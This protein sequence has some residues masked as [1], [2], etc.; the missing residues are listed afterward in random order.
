MDRNWTRRL[1][2]AARR[3]AVT[4]AN[5]NTLQAD[6]YR[7]LKNQFRVTGG[8][9]GDDKGDSQEQEGKGKDLWDNFKRHIGKYNEKRELILPSGGRQGCRLYQTPGVLRSKTP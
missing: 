3:E 6:E 2:R 7:L 8:N 9:A 4:L 5:S 1:V